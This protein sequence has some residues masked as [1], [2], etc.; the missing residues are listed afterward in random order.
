MELPDGR[1]LGATALAYALPLACFLLGLFL[2][3]S[4]SGG[5]ELWA[6]LGS[7]IGLSLSAVALRLFELRLRQRPEWTPRVCAVYPDKP[8]IEDIGC[9]GGK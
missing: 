4:L 6:L 5:M 3:Y 1:F 8:E 2:G 7:A 9:G